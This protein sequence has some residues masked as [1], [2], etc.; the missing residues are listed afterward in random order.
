MTEKELEVWEKCWASAYASM[1][2]N[3]KSDY[4]NMRN[5]RKTHLFYA[6]LLPS[7]YEV[8]CAIIHSIGKRLWLV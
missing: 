6:A 8:F 5:T 7:K 1:S 2:S 3:Y 4:K